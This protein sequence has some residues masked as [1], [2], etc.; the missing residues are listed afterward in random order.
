ML[1]MMGQRCME[2]MPERK[3]Q[4]QQLAQQWQNRNRDIL[5]K[6][7]KLFDFMTAREPKFVDMLKKMSLEA[8][9]ITL[10]KD[11]IEGV[12]EGFMHAQANESY[13]VKNKY[14]KQYEILMAEVFKF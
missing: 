14:K 11:R 9:E 3:P 10:T 7:H 1:S 4:I 13:D 8:M 12:C 5:V 6:T 2:Q